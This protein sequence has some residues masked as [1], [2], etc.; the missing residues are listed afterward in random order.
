[1]HLFY[2]SS[3]LKDQMNTTDVNDLSNALF[4]HA[5]FSLFP[6]HLAI[7]SSFCD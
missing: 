2:L 6:L 5:Q 4:H 7:V 1:M 3:L